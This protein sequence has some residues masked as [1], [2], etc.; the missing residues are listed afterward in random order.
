M[1]FIISLLSNDLS[2]DRNPSLSAI[3]SVK[4][5]HRGL[6]WAPVLFGVKLAFC[7]KH[8]RRGTERHRNTNPTD[9]E[10]DTEKAKP[11]KA[12]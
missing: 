4:S 10:S 11:V 8:A 9:Q 2:I 7:G 12:G 5:I 1:R 6:S 3:R